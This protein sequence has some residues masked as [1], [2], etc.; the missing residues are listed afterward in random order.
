MLPSSSRPIGLYP[1]SGCVGIVPSNSPSALASAAG[2]YFT[3]A[4]YIEEKVTLSLG[5]LSN[6]GWDGYQRLVYERAAAGIARQAQ[7]FLARGYVTT[8]ELRDLVEVQRNGLVVSMRKRLTP[9][10]RFY[11]EKLKSAKSLPTVDSLVARKGSPMAVLASVG[12]T[13]AVTNRIAVFGRYAGPAGVVLDIVVVGVVIQQAP[14]QDRARI[15]TR[16]ISGVVGSFAA[17][18]GG[19]WAGG[20]A[21]ATWAGTW[22]APTLVIPVVGTITEGTAIV[23]GGVA[24]AFIGSWLGRSAGQA[25]GDQI[26][27]VAPVEWT[28]YV[29]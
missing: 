26:W 10:G 21:G 7:E 12:K 22:A 2:A 8:A 13:R 24:G 9:F 14:E 28:E 23:L 17:G 18:T 6:L 25:V 3:Q 20:V 5:A 16:E 19:M 4:V 15:A 27:R 11:S 29:G 1:A